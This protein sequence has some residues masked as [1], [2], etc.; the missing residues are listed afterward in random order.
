MT[1]DWY[2]E[3]AER[4]ILGAALTSP[5]VTTLV[6]LPASAF[7]QPSHADLWEAICAVH[8]AGDKPD[9]VTIPKR[10]LP[11]RRRAVLGLMADVISEGLPSNAEFYAATIRDLAERR[12]ISAAV[13]G[14]RQ[15]LDLLDLPTADIMAMA[16]RDL[17][18]TGPLDRTAEQTLSFDEFCDQQIPA[19]DWVIDRLLARGERLVLTGIEGLG[20]TQMLRQL[21]V[22]AAAGVDPFTLEDTTPRRVL[23]VDAENPNGIM[24][25]KLGAMREVMRRRGRPV[26][27]RMWIRRFPQGLD[28]A[29]PTDRLELHHLCTIVRP[30]LLVIGPAYK[31]YVGGAGAREEDLARQVT[32]VLDG[33]REEFNFA[34]LLEHHSPHAGPG[35][36]QRTVRPI[37][38]SLWLRW[39]E[40]GFGIRPESGTVLEDRQVEVKHWRGAREAR[41]WPLRLVGGGLSELPWTDPSYGRR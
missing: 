17:I 6:K 5:A 30:D 39:P 1:G 16:E 34:L 18:T 40:I 13:E 10:V 4:S 26:G 37:G 21:A 9:S 14:L 24:V 27:N 11:A 3:T 38:S 19:E 41:P 7:G 29:Q 8:D 33:L 35:A 20:K 36:E 25:R 32:S 22:S 28:L 23:Y 15:R 31:L 2:D 12:R